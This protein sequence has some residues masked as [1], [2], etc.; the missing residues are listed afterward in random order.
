MMHKKQNIILF[1]K[2]DYALLKIVNEIFDKELPLQYTKKTFFPHFHPHGIKEM[3][4]SKGLRIAFAVA[5]LLDSLEV[6]RADDR[7]NALRS[8]HEEILSTAEG[9]MPVNT[10]RVLLEIMK[11]LIRERGNL[12]RQLELAHNFRIA[13]AGK[14]HLIRRLLRKYH[15]L[16]MPAQWN[17]VAFDDHVH[18][19]STK[20]RKSG[21]HLIMDAWI[22][23]IRRL[24]VIYY[25]HIHPA[26][27]MELLEAAHI[28]GIDVRIGIEFSANF[29]NKYVRIIWVPRGFAD[30][31]GFMCMLAD[32]SIMNLMSEG[33]KASSY[34]AKYVFDVLEK[35]NNKHRLKINE[36]YGLALPAL[37][38]KAFADFVGAGQ[39][40]ILHLANF[41]HHRLLKEMQEKTLALK[42]QYK[43]A[44]PDTQK[45]IEAQVREMNRLDAETL[46]EH[47]LNPEN[48]P[49]ID[50]PEVPSDAADIPEILKMTPSE[51][52]TKLA[53]L[54]SAYR[55]T[56]NLTNLYVEDV[57]EILYDCEGRI[58]R[59]EIFNLKDYSQGKIDHIPEINELQQ[60]IN[61]ENAIAI[62]RLIRRVITRLET[63]SGESKSHRI[64]KLQM[65]LHDIDSFRAMY[66]GTPLKAR[67]G[68]DSTSRS[69]R[70]HGMGL[71]IIDTLP[72]RT[73][74]DIRKPSDSP[75]DMIPIE[76]RPY[77]RRTFVPRDP[78]GF[79]TRFIFKVLYHIPIL[80]SFCFDYKDDWDVQEGAIHVK[81]KGNIVTLGGVRK[82]YTNDL[83]IKEK[84]DNHRPRR[85]SWRYLNTKLKNTLK[86]LI[87]FIPAF[88]TFYIM[89]DWWVLSYLGAVIWFSITGFRNVLQSVFGG[90]GFWRS[91]LIRWNDYVSWERITDSLLFTGFS[92]PLLDL[93]VKTLLL[94]R[95][96][97]INTTTNPIALYSI[98]ALANGIYISSHNAFRGFPR[99][100]VFGNFF[101]SVLSIP[102]AIV[103]NIGLGFIL[104]LSGF[105][106]IAP[107]L[108]KWAAVISKLAS[109]CVAGIIEGTAD[110]FQNIRIRKRDYRNKFKQLF[111]VYTE[112]ELLFPEQH[113]ANTVISS[114]QLFHTQKSEAYEL[115]KI[116]MINA[117]DLLYFWMYQPRARSALKK[118]I[119][120]M[121]EEEQAIFIQSQFILLQYKDISQLFIDGIVGRNFM[122]ALAFYLNRSEEYLSDIQKI[123]N[124]SLKI[125]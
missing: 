15:L 119:K 40:S 101:R 81:E 93:L 91:P 113:I 118:I 107:I 34:Q 31:Q 97:G 61:S 114:D 122:K 33:Q 89:Y 45:E 59:L 37:D 108:Q 53:G 123:V 116:L 57:I 35:F 30:A 80:R 83:A 47:Y 90:G 28:M 111:N 2:K 9:S 95:G 36:T 115:R 46:I 124:T 104:Q 7:L 22:K 25:N 63:Q 73:Q 76:I 109:D 105:T 58:T 49:D 56:L 16:E 120:S 43:N 5:Y 39:T 100:A 41:I 117:L 88:S 125:N 87:G 78:T 74:I 82:E 60:A 19:A 98:I 6:G 103:F 70:M 102:I 86:V 99:G 12:F 42:A 48:N 85:L 17:Q 4:E 77:F 69:K 8:L 65:I 64:N 21:S 68:S 79:L 51:I 27:A 13:A 23:G 66:K 94:D 20:G 106:E 18:D 52:I 71:A 92:V 75:R 14:P 84:V 1:D 24:R 3:S 29:R 10:A 55:I 54:Y 26:S 62:K 72:K 112:L 32:P 121:S 11:E 38:Q 67:I 96:F 44:S 110:R 50:N